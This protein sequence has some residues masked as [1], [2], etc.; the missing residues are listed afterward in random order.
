MDITSKMMYTYRQE[1]VI[2]Q[3]E[4]KFD[5]GASIRFAGQYSIHTSSKTQRLAHKHYDDRFKGC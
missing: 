3:A 4:R 1:M 2:N 5:S